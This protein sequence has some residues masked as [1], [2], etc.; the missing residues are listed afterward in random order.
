MFA[1]VVLHRRVP[2]RFESFT[3]EIPPELNVAPGQIVRVPFR[4]Q[5]LSAVVRKLHDTKPPYPTKILAGSLETILAP[6][7]IALADWMSEQYQCSFS[8]TI[9]FFV[10][11][12]FWKPGK[13]I[14]ERVEGGGR[15]AETETVSE[16]TQIVSLVRKL[17][18][19][20]D[21]TL[22]LEKTPLPR[23]EF[24]R[25][26]EERLPKNSRALFLF[27]E[28]F[29]AKQLVP[30]LPLYHGGLKENEKAALWKA[31]QNGDISTIAG[32]R[33]AL[34]LPFKKLS[35]IV[36]DFEHHE[37]Y[38]EI[39]RPNYHSLEVA[40]KLAELW[41]IPLVVLSSTTRVET[42]HK[43]QTAKNKLEIFEEKNRAAAVRI[44]N[45]ADER[46]RGN[47]DLLAGETVE[48][49]ARALAQKQ[50]ILLFLN[51]IGE[52]TALL[53]RD[54][55]KIFRCEKCSSPLAIRGETELRCHRCRIKKPV[56]AS[57]DACGNIKLKFL[58]AGTER[59]EKEIRKIFAKAEIV[60]LDRETVSSFDGL[61]MTNMAQAD[62][63]VATQIIDKPFDLP[64]LAVS[65][66][67]LPDPLLHFPDFRATERVFQ[68]LTHIRHLTALKGE[69]LIQ[70]FLPEHKLFI[71]LQ[72]N[73]IEKFYE[74]ELAARQSLNLPPFWNK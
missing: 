6:R 29:F 16:K 56:P 74:E 63:L 48:K 60:R 43:W 55:G 32:T 17:L 66:A 52:A 61:K 33:T 40:E 35:C 28:A 7:Q 23:K 50:Q 67:V 18:E 19:A 65:I 30:H 71:H 70:T 11:E 9:D 10:P 20:P 68:L 47:F 26:I 49:I 54:C 64:R 59:L 57:C 36:L 46:R 58:G 4:K 34:F 8:K 5:I 44:I 25:A 72:K 15:M 69:M 45:M 3:Y 31:I 53:C 73:S 14:G 12:N 39:R 62:I 37:S 51:R 24:Y 1:E 2:S 22:L 38:K 41:G 13:K 21:K 27:P 42:W